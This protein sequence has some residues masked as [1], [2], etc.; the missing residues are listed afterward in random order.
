M[1]AWRVNP[2]KGNGPELLEPLKASEKTAGKSGFATSPMT[3]DC[4]E[5]RLVTGGGHELPVFVGPGQLDIRNSTEIDF[6]LFAPVHDLSVLA[7]VLQAHRSPYEFPNQF[8][9]H[10]IDYEGTEWAC[11]VTPPRVEVMSGNGV[12]LQE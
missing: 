3:V 8:R 2:L 6:K 7:R 11:G 9:L 12:S 5:L 1:K 10:A 4:P